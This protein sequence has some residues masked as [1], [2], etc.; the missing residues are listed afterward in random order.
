MKQGLLLILITVL[1]LTGCSSSRQ[2]RTAYEGDFAEKGSDTDITRIAHTYANTDAGEKNKI[3][4]QYAAIYSNI[5]S[6]ESEK[7]TRVVGKI[8]GVPVTAK[9]FELEALRVQ[10]VG[11]EDVYSDAWNRLEIYISVQQLAEKYEISVD[12]D[13]MKQT[14]QNRQWIEE[15]K[16]GPATKYIY[17]L[18]KAYSMTEDEFWNLQF[19]LMK[20][21]V[22][23]SRVK[24]YLKEHN[25]PEMNNVYILSEIT[26]EKYIEKTKG[27]KWDSKEEN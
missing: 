14:N 11:S 7:A 13:A 10:A 6:D 18:S 3:E 8:E 2:N 23:T 5:F 21:Q 17:D 12:E 15:E 24:Q 1:I 4:L 22:L 16:N 26:D 9:E 25:L 27:M 20:R 19:E